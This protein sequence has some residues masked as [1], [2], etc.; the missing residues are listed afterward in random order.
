MN[1][2]SMTPAR[3][4]LHPD[5]PEWKTAGRMWQ[6]IPGIER[7]ANGRLYA[8][9]YSGGKTEEPGN[10]VIL[11]RSDDDGQTWT[12]GFCAVHHDDPE[13]RCFDEAIWIDPR[14]RLWLFWT[15]SRLF[16][17]GRNG[18][19]CAVCDEPDADEIAFSEPR[20]LFDGLM[21]NKP[22]AA[23]TGEWYFPVALWSRAVI[24]PLEEHPE[25][26]ERRL[27]GVYVTADG[28][29]TFQWRGGAGRGSA[30]GG[31]G[32]GLPRCPLGG[33]RGGWERPLRALLGPQGSASSG[34]GGGVR[35]TGQG[36]GT[37]WSREPRSPPSVGTTWRS[38]K[39]LAF[40]L[41]A[42]TAPPLC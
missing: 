36:T 10:I 39:G 33:R 28:G 11:E 37:A 1:T 12:D 16:Y 13:V 40:G 35:T 8:C 9:W 34:R 14:G 19:W 25:L 2:G 24:K 18:V 22:L 38:Q 30:P 5:R 41:K 6:G 7:T 26:D 31:A 21:L 20:R 4:S 32:G 15:Q 3:V 29:E 42:L 27:S 17:D 23:S